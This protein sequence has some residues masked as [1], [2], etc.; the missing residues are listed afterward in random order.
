MVIYLSVDRPACRQAGSVCSTKLIV[1]YTIYAIVFT[2]RAIYVGMTSD[3]G[4]RIKE[5][6]RGKTKSTKGK[7][8]VRVL[9]IEKCNCRVN[10]RNREKYWKSGCGKEILKIRILGD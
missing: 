10:A 8:I 4:R 3:L 2:N 5:H 9:S 6:I 1:M 7:K